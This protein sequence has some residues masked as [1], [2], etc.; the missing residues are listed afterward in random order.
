MAHHTALKYFSGFLLVLNLLMYLVALGISAWA[1]NLAIDYYAYGVI[2][3]KNTIAI[4]II[5]IIPC[6]FSSLN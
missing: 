3:G 6:M 4:A 1:M 5:S 2:S